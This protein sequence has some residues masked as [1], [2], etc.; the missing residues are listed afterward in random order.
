MKTLDDS[1][2]QLG[3]I[4][5]VTSDG[6]VSKGIRIATNSDVS[7][8]MIYVE[9]CSVV[10]SDREGVHARNTLRMFWPD[11]CAAHVLRMRGGMSDEQLQRVIAYARG[12]VGARYGVIE[13]VRSAPLTAARTTQ[14]RSRRQFCSRLVA[15]AYEAAGCLLVESPDYCTPEDIKRSEA[16]VE[17]PNATRVASDAEIAAMNASV[18][19]TQIMRDTTNTLLKR[20]REIDDQIENLNDIDTCLVTHPER[21]ARI[22]Q[23]FRET[24]Y[25]TVWQ[26][27]R[28]RSPW[29]YDLQLMLGAIAPDSEKRWYCEA[30]LRDYEMGLQRYEVNRAGYSVLFETHRLESFRLLKE[31]YERLVELHRLRGKVAAEWLSRETPGS[32]GA[33]QPADPLIPH[34]PEWFLA[35]E[36]YNPVQAA[37]TRSIIKQAAS[38]DVCSICGDAPVKDYRL[39]GHA[40]QEGAV[41]TLRLCS[42]CWG[43]RR[44]MYTESFGLQ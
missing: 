34:S 22:A 37:H 20:V 32:S 9:A 16:L 43:I 14:I 17:V 36:Q 24:G 8:A 13:A 1:I 42:D 11:H 10:D 26:M 21:D 27:E 6:K 41:T 30:T 39:V 5:L 35:L 38:R 44:A 7:H 12:L 33:P 29:Y 15:Q 3:D 18:D 25:L 2:L 40:I 31:L 4:I 19:L 28:S 23:L